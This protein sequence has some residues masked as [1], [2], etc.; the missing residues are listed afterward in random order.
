MQQERN[1]IIESDQSFGS[2]EK[3]EEDQSSNTQ[4]FEPLPSINQFIF[5]SMNVENLSLLLT[6]FYLAK[7][8]VL[9]A[10]GN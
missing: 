9:N 7:T 6:E 3:N 1:N 2:K 4:V 5:E 8:S 10:K